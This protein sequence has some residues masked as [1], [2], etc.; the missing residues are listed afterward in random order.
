MKGIQVVEISKEIIHELPEENIQG[1]FLPRTE[2]SS[3]SVGIIEPWKV[4][5][6]H[7]HNR[8]GDGVEIVFIYSGKCT[9]VSEEGESEVFDTDRNGPVYI[10]ISTKTVAHIR[11]VGSTNVYFFSVFA[12]GLVPEEIVFLD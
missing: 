10:C 3:A 4:Q 9:L 5:K 2:Y 11:N 1:I 12:P 6:K 8:K 7:Y